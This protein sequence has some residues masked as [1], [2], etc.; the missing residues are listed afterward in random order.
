MTLYAQWEEIAKVFYTVKF[1]ANGGTGDMNKITAESGIEIAIT[2][3]SFTKAGWTFSGWN[4]K[5]D[6]TGAPYNDKTKITLTAD[7]ILYAQWAAGTGTAYKVEHWQQNIT[8]DDYTLA[9]TEPMTGT[10]GEET[11]AKAEETAGF[12]AKEFVQ[13]KI[14]EDG[15]AVI[16]IH[17]DRKI[18]IL[19]FDADN[20]EDNTTLSGKFGAEIVSPS[21]EK[22]DFIFTGWNTDKIPNESSKSYKDKEK[23]TLTEDLTLY[24]QWKAG[25]GTAY[26]VEH[27]QQNITDDNYTLA[28]TEPMTG[29]TGEETAA[30]AEETAGFT[31][32][33][34]AQAK[35]AADGSTVIKIW[36]DRKIIT[37]TFDTDNGENK[38]T[39]SGKFGAEIVS[40]SPEKTDFIFTG[41]STDKIPNES[42]KFYNGKEKITFTEDLTLYAQWKEIS[43]KINYE[44]NGGTNAVENPATF[45]KSDNVTLAEPTYEYFDFCGWYLTQDFSSEAVTGW[46]A[47]EKNNDI[48]LYAKWTVKAENVVNAINNLTEGTHNICV[49]GEID[50]DTVKNIGEALHSNGNAKVNLDL[51]KTTGLENI[52]FQAFSDCANLINIE[53]PESVTSIDS[54]AFRNCTNLTTIEIPE[55]VTSIGGDA[56]ASCTNLTSIK[57]PENV[58]RISIGMFYECTNLANIEIPASVT[59]IG[60]YAFGYCTS[61]TNIEIPKNVTS[62]GGVAFRGC[63][64][65][66]DIRIPASVTNIGHS[67]FEE[68][69]SLTT[70]NFL[71]TIEQWNSIS[72]NSDNENLTSAKIICTDGV[73]NE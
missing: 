30:K 38:T 73:I 59:H 63:T 51:S 3:N 10:T 31:A 9:K 62:I 70:V 17:Y 41:W 71:G 5:S 55:S 50:E 18:I 39:L 37:L 45:K 23:I 49:V 26:K 58:T 7:V 60:Y 36:Y 16:K 33:E 11:A 27:W 43:Y 53:I 68:C 54:Y 14:A 8:D 48:T 4:T 57:I 56:F 47:N 35:I 66:T 24:A 6:G 25:T 67:V 2:E 19:T 69:S 40:P 22:T 15:S 20:G 32:K 13:E 29:T 42:S 65:L 52:P 28:K 64:S 72:V 1:D 34:F 46:N 61:L 12:T 21:P 44:L